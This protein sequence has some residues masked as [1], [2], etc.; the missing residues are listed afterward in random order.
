[1]IYVT[2]L[3]PREAVVV[4][5]CAL[6]VVVGVVV[7]PTQP[8]TAATSITLVGR[9]FGHGIG[10]SQYGARYRAE[11]GHSYSQI[12][13]SY[14][15]GTTLATASDGDNIRVR[16]ESDADHVTTVQ[17]EPGLRVQTSLGTVTLPTTVG[18]GAPTHWRIRI[19]GGKLVVEAKV[20]GT[21][22]SSGSTAI[23]NILTGRSYA[24]FRD[25]DG[26]V[27]LVLGTIYREYVGVVRAVRPS[28]TTSTLR[29]VVVSTFTNYLPSVVASEMP[30]S[31]AT[32]ALR[33]QAVAARTYSMFDAAAKPSGSY[34]DTCDTTSCQVFKGR[35]D[36]TSS[37]TLVATHA[38]ATTI[39]AVKDTA[40]RY[41]RYDGGPAFTQFSA[42]NGGYSVAGSRPYLTAAPDPYD[43]YPAWETTLTATSLQSA[44]PTIGR[45]T[46]VTITRDGKGA[47][48]GRA[49]TVRV[50][51]STGSVTVTGTQFRSTFG[52]RSTLFTVAGVD[53]T[54]TR[55][56]TDDGLA[57]L[58]SVSSDRR[59]YLWR[60]DG[61]MT[62]SSPTQLGGTW[63]GKRQLTSVLSLAG[64]GRPEIIAR[65]QGGDVLAAY[66]VEPSGVLGSRLVVDDRGGWE[67]YDLFIGIQGLL[68]DDRPGL[69]ARGKATGTLYYFPSD[70]S[71]GLGSRVSVSGGWSDKRLATAA[72]DW[73][74][75]GHPDV[76]VID[77][78]GRLWLYL[79]SGTPA[80]D[81]RDLLSTSTAWSIRTSIVA[82][83][84]WNG[85]G[86]LDMISTDDSGRLWRN[87]WASAGS[88][89]A[90]VIVGTGWTRRLL[91]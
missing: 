46:R 6:L 40:G 62:W 36:Y 17:S 33:A 86:A 49:V 35:A 80:F 39:A 75:D 59:A 89:G 26:S 25:T 64:S 87:S 8:A 7:A 91:N 58:V 13:A 16:I 32:H 74:G 76:V 60:G 66:P 83:A 71:G 5:V 47:Y 63:S 84:D 19:S 44:Y 70:G 22:R 15:P 81:G 90:G 61:T 65:E 27:R 31:W 85:D 72:G 56:L 9:G 21:W 20:A 2:Y 67:R 73:N 69:L 14:Y 55:D 42:S 23:A 57:D 78:A 48:G 52:L 3:R 11:A 18:G 37:G 12:V 77:D 34:Y 4:L 53:Q 88:I 41:L 24:Q 54:G 68:G 1:M 43:R 30:S 38:V 79:G 51:G 10:M 82:G 50:Q 29:T 45:F 28:G